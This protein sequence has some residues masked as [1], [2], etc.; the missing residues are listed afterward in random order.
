MAVTRSG[1]NDTEKDKPMYV[2]PFASGFEAGEARKLNL[3]A[4]PESAFGA[5]APPQKGFYSFR[6]MPLGKES[7]SKKWVDKDDQSKGFYYSLAIELKVVSDDKDVDG[8]PV[9]T[10]VSTMIGR[11]K[12]LSTLAAFIKMC[13][14]EPMKPGENEIEDG[15]LVQRFARFA[16]SMPVVPR[17]F[18]LD[19]NASYLDEKTETWKNVLNRYEDFPEDGKG[20]RLYEC[21]VTV[22]GLDGKPTT[23]EVRARAFIR[24]QAKE[25]GS[26]N[27]S[28]GGKTITN[29]ASKKVDTIDEEAPKPKAAATKAKPTVV[30]PSDID[31]L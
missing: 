3:N 18:Q 15:V 29:T 11:G 28:S 16:N 7:V 21:E 8:Y 10:Y 4:E 25:E 20:G 1:M 22:P 13:G 9:T 14:K 31:D 17:K 19:W 30:V 23:K 26:T 12:E 5:G 2:D 27:S 24:W 6:L